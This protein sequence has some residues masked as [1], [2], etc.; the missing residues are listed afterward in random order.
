MKT[1]PFSFHWSTRSRTQLKED[2]SGSAPRPGLPFLPPELWRKIIGFT[3]RITGATSLELEDPFSTPYENEEYPIIDPLL[4]EDR[5]NVS[6][7]CSNW[8]SVVLDISAEYL[9]VR[10]D[11]QLKRLFKKLQSCKGRRMGELTKRVDFDM[12]GDYNVPNVVRLL[13]M[14]PNLLIYNNHNRLPTNVQKCTSIEVMRALV[15]YCGQSLKRIEWSGS[16]SPRYEDFVELCNGLPELV[17]IRLMAMHS[18]PRHRDGV[19]PRLLLPRLKCLS[20]GIIPDNDPRPQYSLTWDPLVQYLSFTPA[21]MPL[22]ERFECDIFP[23]HT[24]SFF[25]MHGHKIRLFRTTSWSVQD[26]LPMTLDLCPNIQSLVLAQG[27]E[28]IPLPKSHP[29]LKRICIFPNIED[30]VNVPRRIYDAAVITPLDTLFK[31]LEGIAAPRLV[32]LRVR[33]TGA[34]VDLINYTTWL[35]FWWIRWNIRGVQFSDK[36]GTSFIH[37]K[38]R[39]SLVHPLS[40]SF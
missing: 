17:T 10:S 36:S 2:P 30:P 39:E 1:L 22:L 20:L 5:K 37:V 26:Y 13:R 21:Q 19:P 33:N 6:L 38:D 9:V 16:E 40:I 23:I 27:A 14:T 28:T 35:R 11:K 7:V 12:Y 29:T 15:E 24:T 18:Y 8:H 25:N 34:F 32:E 31:S 4:F 3:V